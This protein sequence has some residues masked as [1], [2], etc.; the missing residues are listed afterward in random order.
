MLF[1]DSLP[2]WLGW[3]TKKQRTWRDAIERWVLWVMS[4]GDACHVCAVAARVHHCAQAGQ[5][6]SGRVLS[7][8]T[9]L[10]GW[11]VRRPLSS[12]VPTNILPPHPTTLQ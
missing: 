7:S 6:E 10:G 12:A 5:E 11:C 4:G 3:H 2:R 8:A 9:K 1:R